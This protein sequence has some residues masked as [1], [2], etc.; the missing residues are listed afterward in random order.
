MHGKGDF[1]HSCVGHLRY[2][3]SGRLKIRCSKTVGHGPLVLSNAIQR[4][5]NPYFMQLS[6]EIGDSRMAE[7]FAMLSL[8][9]Q[10]GIKLPAEDQG[11]IPLHYQVNTWATRKGLK[12]NARADE[13]TR[14]LDLVKAN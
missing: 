14:G 1:G 4:S 3:R 9:H 2:G 13:S 7:V 6:N 10:P 11:I 12:Y 8:G 5:G